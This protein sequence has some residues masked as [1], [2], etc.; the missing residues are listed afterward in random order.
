MTTIDRLAE[1]LHHMLDMDQSAAEETLRNYLQQV[2]QIDER[3]IDEDDI[4]EDDA[5]FLIGAVK[6]ARRAGD[7]G[8]LELLTLEETAERYRAV[9]D[10]ADAARAERDA[11]IR[12]A[13]HAGASQAAVARAAGVSRQAISK[14]VR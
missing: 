11:C 5:D 13:L 12:K 7:L 2:E 8:E 14:M 4:D 9:L 6:A 10:N 3:T 1:S